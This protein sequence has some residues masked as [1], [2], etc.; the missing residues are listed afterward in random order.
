MLALIE[1]IVLLAI[2]GGCA[3]YRMKPILW[4][5]IMGGMLI[6]FSALS[7]LSWFIL[8]PIWLIYLASA[9]LFNFPVLRKKV[10]TAPV[11]SYFKSKLPPMSRTEQE[12]IDAGDTWWEKE[13]F[14]G[15][16]DWSVLSNFKKP[17][18]TPE[19]K[20]FIE[21]PV[22]TLCAKL[23]AFEIEESREIP[24]EIWD[25]LRKE[26]FFGLCI[27]KKYG[28]RGFSAYAHSSVIAKISSRSLSTAVTVM[29]PNSLGPAEL[30]YHYGTQEQKDYYLPRLASGE[31][32]PCFGLTGP[33][34][35][36][37]A[38]AIPDKGIVCKGTYKGKE[39]LGF[40]LTWD[41]RYITLA[42]VATLLGL[43]FK[44]YDPQG[45]L[46][47]KEDL[48][49]TLCLV[50]TNHPGVETG[51]RHFPAG[52]AFMNGPTR[53][54][55]VFIP[56][57][58]IIGGETQVGQGWKMLMACLSIG[59]SISLPAL[60]TAAATL[61]YAMT[62]A[63]ARIR[64]QF[65][66]SIA[67]FE[68]V[69]EALANI[70]GK[71]YLIEATRTMTA[72]AVDLGV[73]PAIASALTKYHTTELAREV[74]D[75]ALDV[76]GGRAVQYGPSNYLGYAHQGIP[77]SITVEGANILTR[78]LIVFGQGVVRCH[79]FIQD[80]IAAAHQED[81][82]KALDSFDSLL[83][84]H[85]GFAVS[86]F[87]KAFWYGLTGG[88]F[89]QAPEKQALPQYYRQLTRM[90]T[91]LACVTDI[92]MMI[93]GGD[94]KRRE[95]LSARLGDVLSYLYMG[96]AVLRYAREQ[97]NTEEHLNMATW[98]LQY[99]LYHI[100][101]A[102]NEFLNNFPLSWVGAILKRILF[103]WGNSYGHQPK[104][105][106]SLEIIEPMIHLSDFR[107]EFL[108]TI[109]L[110]KGM[111]DPT[112][113]IEYAFRA[114]LAS[115]AVERKLKKILKE[116]HISLNLP[117]EEQLKIASEKEFLTKEEIDLMSQTAEAINK[118]IAVDDFTDEELARKHQECI[119][120][121][122]KV[123]A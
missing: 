57:E 76:H 39:V 45:L 64:K 14:Q 84:S 46:G 48:G 81:E 16:P 38:G 117:L 18:L 119:E 79:P 123:M 110:G 87:V 68:G 106:L 15:N 83:C 26:R 100:Q 104:D 62:G 58:F 42:P 77:V 24:Q 10:F 95:R 97:G 61:S 32:I 75:H 12:A 59:R 27:D 96:S 29:V 13:L 51:L 89:I 92:A 66:T 23:H 7:V 17:T 113:C 105:A 25:Y 112:G 91:S 107:K 120:K 118:A 43:A 5:S 121:I 28:G 56:M 33:L 3:F 82:K 55:D 70:A 72:S 94:L 35:G 1:L 37:D 88:R 40:R 2:A 63:Y 102:F 20:A 98:C 67:S 47:G 111:E 101:I 65:K 34:A 50:P 21:G 8:T 4:T 108:K 19:E 53:G 80:E 11:L 22:E 116:N 85:I 69:Q 73:K 122:A 99:C 52:L 41:K 36:S 60:S 109:F 86:N 31:D 54:K 30:V 9:V 74:L 93:L 78:N 115:A 90:S 6:L 49:I 71:A 44:M 114:V 103:P